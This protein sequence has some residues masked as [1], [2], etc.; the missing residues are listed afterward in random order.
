MQD[1]RQF[2]QVQNNSQSAREFTASLV[3]L[4]KWCHTVT[5]V[6]SSCSIVPPFQNSVLS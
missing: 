2:V 5:G 4:C 3:L 6:F 1:E